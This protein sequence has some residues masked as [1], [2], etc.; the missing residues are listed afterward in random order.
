MG[1][2]SIIDVADFDADSAFPFEVGRR[3]LVFAEWRF[4]GSDK[5]RELTP[6]GY[7]QGIYPQ[8]DD[9]TAANAINGSVD[10]SRLPTM[11]QG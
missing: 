2:G 4:L 11:L 10:L 1:I 9:A 7:Y 8:I 5:R 3:Y 6:V